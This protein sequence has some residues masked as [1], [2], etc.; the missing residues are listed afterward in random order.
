MQVVDL[1]LEKLHEAP[2][3]P[4]TMDKE[5]LAKLKRSL[6]QYGLVTNLVVRPIGDDTYE[7]LSGNQRLKVL[8]EL[9]Y[10]LAPCVLADLDDAHARL[11]AQAL[12]RIQG[13]DDLGLR[14]ELVREVLKHLT[15]EE[16]L[17]ILPETLVSL[18]ALASLGQQ[19]IAQQLEAWQQAQEARLRHLQFQLTQCQLEVIEEALA[20]IMPQARESRGESPNFKG[21]ALYLLCKAFLEQ[22]K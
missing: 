2:W 15:E 12:N 17:G 5:T 10:A 6:A 11:L 13:E 1:P 9:G 3:N 16:V 20:R 8:N 18:K 22:E 7:V 14:A 4:N 19:T 21:I